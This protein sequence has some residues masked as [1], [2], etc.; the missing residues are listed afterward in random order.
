MKI[1]HAAD[2]HLGSVLKSKFPKEISNERK[3]ETFDTF[4]RMVEN[5]EKTGVS[6]IMLSGDVFDSE[7]SGVKDKKNFYDVIRNHP[8]IDFLYL[9]GNHDDTGSYGEKADNLKN[10]SNE[11][12]ITYEYEDVAISGIEMTGDNAETFYEKIKLPENKIN[13]LMLHGEIS[14]TKGPDKIKL[15]EL[16]GKGI[17][18]LALGHIHSFKHGK[19]GENSIYAYPGCLEGR[20]FD[21]CGEKGYILLN[22]DNEIKYEFV[23][24]AY[25]TIYEKKV[26][27]TG[28]ETF[29]EIRKRV[30]DKIRDIDDKNIVRIELCG[31]TEAETDFDEDDVKVW[32]RRFYFSDICVNTETKINAADY[33]NDK[34]LLGEFVRR[35]EENP[36]YSETMK[37]RLITVGLRAINGRKI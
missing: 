29:E 34:S 10:F 36:E 33:K 3:A 26:D 27:L 18:Y 23:P 6:V 24:F 2:L 17:D 37:K 11:M 30:D 12:L 31:E 14:D 4:V 22:I 9:N 32:L 13:I 25:R 15:K 20:G 35:V 7:K 1:I 19:F 16:Q 21:E 5:A 28:A 8:D